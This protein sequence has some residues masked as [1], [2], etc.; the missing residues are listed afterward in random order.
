[1]ISQFFFRL[2]QNDAVAVNELCTQVLTDEIIL[3]QELIQ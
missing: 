2:H 1:M 3:Y